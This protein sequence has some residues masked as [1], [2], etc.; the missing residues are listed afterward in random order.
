MGSHLIKNFDF[1]K[2]A[3]QF[4]FFLRSEPNQ[5]FEIILSEK[6][7]KIL[8]HQIHLYR[9]GRK[10]IQNNYISW[11]CL[12]KICQSTMRTNRDENLILNNATVIEIKFSIIRWSRK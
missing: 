11:R 2:I 10:N 6:S 8:V 4:K 5:N 3:Q 7:K 1:K 12:T 9:I